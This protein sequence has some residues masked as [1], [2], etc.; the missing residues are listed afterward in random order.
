MTAFISESERLTDYS[1]IYWSLKDVEYGN[2]Y[3]GTNKDGTFFFI[4]FSL[5]FPNNTHIIKMTK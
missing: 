2:W 1:K 3:Q 4:N 5:C